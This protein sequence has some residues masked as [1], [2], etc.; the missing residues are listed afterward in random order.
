MVCVDGGF[1]MQSFWSRYTNVVRR[2][3]VGVLL[4][5]SPLVYSGCGGNETSSPNPIPSATQIPTKTDTVLPAVQRVSF[6][7][8]EIVSVDAASLV[9]V[10][11][12]SGA[13]N[14][15]VIPGTTEALDFWVKD[16]S[17]DG[18]LALVDCVSRRG[19]GKL[20]P[21]GSNDE[22]GPR[23]W[24]LLNTETGQT[25]HLGS[26]SSPFVTLSP[27]GNTLFSLD[28]DTAVFEP[29]DG[30]E[31]RYLQLPFKVNSTPQIW[32]WSPQGGAVA[33]V[34]QH[35]ESS[36]ATGV[37]TILFRLDSPEPMRL[38]SGEATIGWAPDGASFAVAS[39]QSAIPSQSA[40]IIAFDADG[41]QLWDAILG[42]SSENLR[43]SPDGNRLAIQLV[44]QTSSDPQADNVLVLDVIDGKT[45][46]PLF[47]LLGAVA[48]S[49]EVWTADGSKL[50]VSDYPYR[51]SVLVD[52]A[53]GAF[54]ALQMGVEPVP[55]AAGFGLT[56]CPSETSTTASDTVANCLLNLLTGEERTL[57]T[58]RT[59]VAWELPLAWQ[60][61]G[62]GIAFVPSRGGHGGCAESVGPQPPLEFRYPPYG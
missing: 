44:L 43:W 41:R 61:T 7:P 29:A 54:K 12:N 53:V 32:S 14:G 21:C 60:F 27:D 2:V 24:Y 42:G 50:I 38:F 4:I 46:A 56:G 35:E 9:F 58:F 59:E 22:L 8:G 25:R 17:K 10:D 51:G 3:A 20:I 34:V 39:S 23:Y 48:C 49:G 5:L 33:V 26:L 28:K 19:D 57:V 31:P 45:G 15:W 18:K 1:S 16:I 30:G 52:P 37:S 11:P 47:R 6:A 40:R 62:K 13:S 55:F 36:G